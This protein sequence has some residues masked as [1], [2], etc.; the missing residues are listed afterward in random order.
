M[1]AAITT[2]NGNSEADTNTLTG[3][4]PDIESEIVLDGQ[5]TYY[6]D[7][8][9]SYRVFRVTVA[10]NFTVQNLTIRNG[11]SADGGGI[12]ASGALTVTNCT[13]INNTSVGQGGAIRSTGST[14]AVSNSTF[15]GNQA[16]EGGGIY[17]SDGTLTVTGSST[18]TSSSATSYAVPFEVCGAPWP[19]RTARSPLTSAVWAARSTPR[20]SPSSI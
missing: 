10:G 15:T 17:I 13:F 16:V 8:G 4:L 11:N 5:S 2:A 14:V 9:N 19:S 12:D 18:F 20:T 1:A 6:V 3:T 7:G